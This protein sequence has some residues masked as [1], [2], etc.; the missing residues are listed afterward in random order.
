[1]SSLQFLSSQ[2]QSISTPLPSSHPV[3]A[4]AYESKGF[5]SPVILKD[6]KKQL[7]LAVNAVFD[8]WDS[9]REIKYRN[10]S[11]GEKKLYGEFLINA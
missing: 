7:E 8:S 11:I 6:P 10:P 1:M 2:S 9:P 5:I 3:F 4:A